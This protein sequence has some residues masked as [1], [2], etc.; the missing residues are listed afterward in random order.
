[1]K[2]VCCSLMLS[3]YRNS[4][5]RFGNAEVSLAKTLYFGNEQ[6]CQCP[7]RSFVYFAVVCLTLRAVM[8]CLLIFLNGITN[9][10][11]LKSFR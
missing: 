2:A 10:Y 11:S 8:S 9:L 3:D 7:P 6:S 4:M 1:V 5:A